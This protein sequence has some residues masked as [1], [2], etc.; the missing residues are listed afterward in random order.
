MVTGD[1]S[2]EDG[3]GEV[4]GGAGENN[5]NP[6]GLVLFFVEVLDHQVSELVLA[7]GHQL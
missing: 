4:E 3:V 6:V 5:P 2:F 7:E 1:V